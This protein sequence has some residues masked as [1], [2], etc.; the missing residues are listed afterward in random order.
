M[1]LTPEGAIAIR[2]QRPLELPSPQEFGA[3]IRDKLK[4]A[5]DAFWKG[6]RKVKEKSQMLSSIITSIGNEGIISSWSEEQKRKF[7]DLEESILGL[8]HEKPRTIRRVFEEVLPK[9]LNKKK[10]VARDLTNLLKNPPQG[11]DDW[12]EA[13]ENLARDL[14]IMFQ[15]GRGGRGRTPAGPSPDW[16]FIIGRTSAP[17]KEPPEERTRREREELT[18]QG[19]EIRERRRALGRVIS[20]VGPILLVGTIIERNANIPILPTTQLLQQQ[21]WLGFEKPER[22]LWARPFTEMALSGKSDYT[23]NEWY[24]AI[25][26]TQDSRKNVLDPHKYD[27]DAKLYL[28]EADH[29]LEG[30][31]SDQIA[32]E[33]S[34][35]GIYQNPAFRDGL[36]W[37]EALIKAKREGR[38]IDAQDAQHFRDNYFIPEVGFAWPEKILDED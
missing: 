7:H 17:Q 5:T 10:P 4:E 21:E 18:G 35:R 19:V 1:E 30:V 24:G 20:I 25:Y 27:D 6:R 37:V 9:R 13:Q 33:L 8:S 23:I 26:N 14:T 28:D 38:T 16:N 22:R 34:Q 12:Q 32:R 11:E 2:A 31:P 36:L 29:G 15:R 3:K